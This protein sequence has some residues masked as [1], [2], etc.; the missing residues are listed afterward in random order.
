M[1][2]FATFTIEGDG[3][4]TKDI[5]DEIIHGRFRELA[6]FPTDAGETS[7]ALDFLVEEF[8]DVCGQRSELSQECADLL[9][10]PSS[11]QRNRPGIQAQLIF[12]Q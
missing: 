4:I 3:G 12:S 8:V 11:P 7:W 1:Q 9:T 5:I 6:S 10:L 2:T